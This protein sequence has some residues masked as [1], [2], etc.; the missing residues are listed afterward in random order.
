MQEC[1]A[2]DA[3]FS[4]EVF[5]NLNATEV[6]AMWEMFCTRGKDMQI[7]FSN[8]EADA[9]SGSAVWIASYTFSSTGR[10]VINAIKAR[11]DL[12]DGKIIRHTDS[13]SFYNWASQAIGPAGILLG[14]TPIVKSKVRRE[15]RKR[16]AEY[17]NLRQGQP[18]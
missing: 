14:W 10:K 15:A 1:Y 7:S 8:V 16:L 12:A 11:F 13:F 3:V 4:D 5:V 2:N 6:R 17:I 9:H 18:I